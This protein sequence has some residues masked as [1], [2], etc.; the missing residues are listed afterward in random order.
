MVFPPLL[1]EA[2]LQ[3]FLSGSDNFESEADATSLTLNLAIALGKSPVTQRSKIKENFFF[4]I[5]VD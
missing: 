4:I 3:A 1:S 2:N 5:A